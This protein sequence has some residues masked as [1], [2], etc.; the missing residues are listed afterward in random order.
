MRAFDVEVGGGFVEEEEVRRAQEEAREGEADALA[1]GEDADALFGGFAG[2]A[3]SAEEGSDFGFGGVGPGG[4]HD[5]EARPG[6]GHGLGGFLA[7]VAGADEVAGTA[8]AF[9]GRQDAGDDAQEGGLA[10]AVGPDDG[11]LVAAVEFAGDGA[12]DPAGTAVVGVAEVGPAEDFVAASRRGGEPEGGASAGERLDDG[13]DLVHALEHLDLVLD[14]GGQ[15]ALGAEAVDE[16]LDLGAAAVF[17]GLPGEEDGAALFA[18]GGVVGV[19]TGVAGHAAAGDFEGE[20]GEGFEEVAVVGDEQEGA[21]EGVE[22]AAEAATFPPA[23]ADTDAD[24][25]TVAIRAKEPEGTESR[26]YEYPAFPRIPSVQAASRR[27]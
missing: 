20:G 12:E 24:W 13:A 4:L 17:V 8:G 5:F 25:L 3:E 7:L 6:G 18:F 19:G 22:A 15:G 2:E 9:G 27:T 26:L 14:A 1:A 21:A 11:D 23:E 10:G 16:A